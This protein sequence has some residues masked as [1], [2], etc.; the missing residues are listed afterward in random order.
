[1]TTTLSL[2]ILFLS[3]GTEERTLMTSFR[4]RMDV[5]VLRQV[6]DDLPYG[7]RMVNAENVPVLGFECRPWKME[8]MG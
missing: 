5:L 2:L 3:N 7:S 1:M 6:M 4:C 8:A